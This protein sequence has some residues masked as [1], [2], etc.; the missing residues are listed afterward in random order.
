MQIVELKLVKTDETFETER[1]LQEATLNVRLHEVE[2]I[3][4]KIESLR[5]PAS[6]EE[7]MCALQRQ[8]DS[9]ERLRNRHQEETVSQKFAIQ[10][11]IQEAILA[12]EEYNRFVHNKLN[13][14]KSHADD[15]KKSVRKLKQ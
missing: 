1:D 6:L 9:L 13:E 5:D 15:R 3:E 8:C 7:Q 11:E 14:L 2:T 4:L 10:Q 12:V